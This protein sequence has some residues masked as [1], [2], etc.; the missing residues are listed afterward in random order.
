M[1]NL[2]EV[3]G[4]GFRDFGTDRDL[5]CGRHK[6]LG[7]RDWANDD[8]QTNRGQGQRPSP[9]WVRFAVGLFQALGSNVG[10]NL[11]GREVGV[12]EQGLH[13]SQ[14]GSIVQKVSSKAVTK[15]VRT[16]AELN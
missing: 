16:H 12:T 5:G 9:S 2:R 8:S 6:G 7:I 3:P 4:V 15:F 14:V 11:G 13:T 1:E 10:I